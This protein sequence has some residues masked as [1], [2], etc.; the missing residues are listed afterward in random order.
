MAAN[1]RTIGLIAGG[2]LVI[3]G[4]VLMLITEPAG[5]E[6]GQA[7]GGVS[8]ASED[9]RPYLW[10]GIISLAVG[11]AVAMAA[12]FFAPGPSGGSS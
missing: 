6:G 10:W 11:I 9:T 3:L 7:S 12:W 4:I 1:M 5:E 2:I 8:D